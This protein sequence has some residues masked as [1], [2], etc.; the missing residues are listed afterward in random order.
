MTSF[1]KLFI[2]Y[3]FA[4]IPLIVLTSILSLTG[5]VPISFN[6]HNYTGV[7]GFIFSIMLLPII[8]L[9][10]SI[11]NWVFLNIG[12]HIYKLFFKKEL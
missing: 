7:L 3:F 11:P 10:L 1:K 2:C 12:Y 9:S 4:S 8:A 5:A 6:D